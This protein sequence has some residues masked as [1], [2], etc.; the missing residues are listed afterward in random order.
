[1]M[2]KAYSVA[3]CMFALC[4]AVFAADAEN[5]Q[6]PAPTTPAETP[7]AK[8]T[9]PATAK[10]NS[11]ADMKEI[12]SRINHAWRQPKVT[13]KMSVTVSF[14]VE[15]TGKLKTVEIKKSSG[16]TTVDQAA[17]A[18]I[19]RA[20]PFPPLKGDYP[21]F[22]INYVFDCRPETN[23][24]DEYMLNGV[25]M[26]EK[27]YLK[28]STGGTLRPLDRSSKVEDKLI[29][30]SLA[31]EDK[32]VALREKLANQEKMTSADDA[33]I[34]PILSDLANAEKQVGRYDES[35]AN[36]KRIIT[37]EEKLGDKRTLASSLA[38]YGDSIYTRAQFANA[39]PILARA[40]LLKRE[41]GLSA[42]DKP[43]L[44]QYA[45]LLYK[46]NRTPEADGIYRELK[47]LN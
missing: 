43:V 38:D 18:T 27:G 6:S 40:L 33:S 36:F 5:A 8:Q 17:V 31:L 26:K 29:A 39:E 42:A 30:R 1:M 16:D 19:K 14:A 24:V 32:I 2:L 10:A 21:G 13:H 44:E 41:L 34:V 23:L 28:T 47:G 45:K 12:T 46:L 25:R 15:K 7:A 4:G 9:D 11:D 35:D 22:T 37:L 3:L 20:Q